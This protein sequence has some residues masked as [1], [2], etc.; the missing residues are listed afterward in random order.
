VLYFISWSLPEKTIPIDL[1][2]S[3]LFKRC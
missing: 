1:L 3:K 2:Q